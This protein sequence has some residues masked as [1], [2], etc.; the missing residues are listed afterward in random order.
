MC[1]RNDEIGFLE[2]FKVSIVIPVYN[3]EDYVGRAIESAICQTYSNVEI[4][5]VNDGSTDNSAEICKQYMASDSR[6]K[7]FYT[8]NRGVSAARNIGIEKCTGDFIQFL[9]SDDEMSSEKTEKL[10]RLIKKK[11]V[12]IV[13]GGYEMYKDGKII[14]CVP[15]KIGRG[16]RFFKFYTIN[17]WFYVL[18]SACTSIIRVSVIKD[19]NLKFDENMRMGEDGLFVLDCL[20]CTKKI[21]YVSN[22]LYKIYKFHKKIRLSAT[23]YFCY[24]KYKFI[25]EYFE[26]INK[27]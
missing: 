25:I 17:E 9:D 8:E 14:I 7:Y 23:G 12:D 24:D 16:N 20:N 26:R 18:S 15:T 6:I 19:N 5:I 13:F 27:Y 4:I 10:M 11:D 22:P 2:E 1:V 3:T 21:G